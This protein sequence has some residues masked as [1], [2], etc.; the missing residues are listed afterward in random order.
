MANM[1]AVFQFQMAS[2]ADGQPI[3]PAVEFTSGIMKFVFHSSLVPV[4]PNF[5]KADLVIS[6][7]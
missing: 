5:F 3:S 1:L 4:R 2:G 7:V 6:N